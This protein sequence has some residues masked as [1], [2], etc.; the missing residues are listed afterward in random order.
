VADAVA[1][2][3]EQAQRAV[4]VAPGLPGRI[5]REPDDLRRLAVDEATGCKTLCRIHG[6]SR[7]GLVGRSCS[8]PAS[9][10][11]KPGVRLGTAAGRAGS[12]RPNVQMLPGFVPMGGARVLL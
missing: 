11:V 9:R 7:Y 8:R 4:D 6:Y 1:H 10:P 3:P 2:G 12:I 5:A